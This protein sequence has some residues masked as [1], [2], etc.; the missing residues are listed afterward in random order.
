MAQRY[1]WKGGKAFCNEAA[2]KM[3]LGFWHNTWWV[4]KGLPGHKRILSTYWHRLYW[5]LL[6][7]SVFWNCQTHAGTCCPRKMA[8]HRS[9]CLKCISL[10][11]IRWGNLYGATWGFYK[12]PQYRFQTLMSYLWPKTGRIS[13]VVSTGLLYVRTRLWTSEI[14]SRYFLR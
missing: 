5:H 7:C 13:L 6:T 1:I 8:Y 11:E 2:Y 14:R 4:E 9:W 3:P 12:R 10:W